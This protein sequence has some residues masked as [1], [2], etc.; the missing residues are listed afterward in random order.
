MTNFNVDTNRVYVHR[1]S[2]GGNGAWHYAVNFSW[3]FGAAGL[4]LEVK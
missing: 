1:F 3:L 4:V 2:N